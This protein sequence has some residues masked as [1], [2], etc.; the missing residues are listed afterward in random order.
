MRRFLSVCM[1]VILA[2]SFTAFTSAEEIDMETF[3]LGH[4]NYSVP[5]G[6]VMKEAQST[7]KLE[8]WHYAK[9]VGLIKGGY[10]Y[11][12]QFTMDTSEVTDPYQYL[13][14]VVEQIAPENSMTINKKTKITGLP[15][16]YGSYMANISD[17]TYLTD[18]ALVLYENY[19]FFLAM[20]DEEATIK[21]RQMH[22]EQMMES[23]SID[24]P[25]KNAQSDAPT[26]AWMK[27]YGKADYD[28]FNSPASENGLDGKM[29]WI[30]GTVKE[31]MAVDGQYV[32]I[33]E[34]ADGRKWMAATGPQEYSIG[35]GT[36]VTIYGVYLGTSSKL[37]N[38]PSLLILRYTTTKA[39]EAQGI[40]LADL[41]EGFSFQQIHD[42]IQ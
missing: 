34:Q 8:R 10:I 7:D 2:L 27:Y 12:G 38:L 6:W 17:N 13:D 4:F 1:V 30:N 20:I 5:A 9:A 35:D 36:D 23:I 26:E 28:Q 16:A 25:N 11:T 39:I 15:C 3:S 21:D 19:I 42:S 37:D 40:R 31:R 18:F 41:Y 33:V 14:T 24:T 32:W 22:F 29:I